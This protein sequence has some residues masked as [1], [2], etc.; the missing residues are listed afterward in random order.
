MLHRPDPT[1]I[2]EQRLDEATVALS[3][4]SEG[5]KGISVGETK[6]SPILMEGSAGVFHL[7]TGLLGKQKKKMMREKASHEKK[8]KDGGQNSGQ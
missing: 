5:A 8:S 1:R 3:L 4:A 6:M 7:L 2:L